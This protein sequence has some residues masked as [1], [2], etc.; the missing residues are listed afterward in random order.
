MIT[1][2]EEEAIVIHKFEELAIEVGIFL[3]ALT[4]EDKPWTVRYITRKLE[5][6]ADSF[7]IDMPALVKVLEDN[8]NLEA[9]AEKLMQDE[10]VTVRIVGTLSAHL[11][12]IASVIYGPQQGLHAV[13]VLNDMRS[14]LLILEEADY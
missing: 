10:R 12:A 13:Q 2:E 11:A 3:S 4:V 7:G 5:T 14:T 9:Q 6:L 1:K 8:N